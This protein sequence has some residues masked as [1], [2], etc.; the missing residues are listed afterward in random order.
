MLN[1]LS[2]YLNLQGTKELKK[3]FKNPEAIS[4]LCEVIVTSPNP[5][6]RQSAAVLLRR[7]FGKKRQW[8]RLNPDLRTRWIISI[9]H[10]ILILISF[11]LQS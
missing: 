4:A 6:I 7:K 10:Y 5:Q 11:Y 9:F 2:I 1:Q 3:A 8:S